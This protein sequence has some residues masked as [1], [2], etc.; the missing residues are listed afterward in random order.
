MATQPQTCRECSAPLCRGNRSGYCR[1]HV[2]GSPEVRRKLADSM[3]RGIQADPQ[4]REGLRRAGRASA[5]GPGERERRSRA[6]RERNLNA[7][8]C[9]AITPEVRRKAAASISSTRMAWCP[10]HLRDEHR[11]LVKSKGFKSAEARKIIEAQN[12]AEMRR[13]RRSVGAV[14]EPFDPSRIVAHESDVALL[15]AIADEFDYTLKDLR[16][17]GWSEGIARARRTCVHILKAQGRGYREIAR[18]LGRTDH[19][20]ARGAHLQFQRKATPHMRAV[21]AAF[22]G[23]PA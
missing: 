13:W 16:G 9:A 11:H 18:L 5:N 20:T 6:A 23:Q 2:T 7:I 22:L 15:T 4:R 17:E 19:T 10:P 3:R 14:V 12:E 1:A 8:G 21:A